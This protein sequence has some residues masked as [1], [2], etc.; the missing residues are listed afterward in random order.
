M[1]WAVSTAFAGIALLVS[2]CAGNSR[3]AVDRP[4]P[5][6]SSAGADA[7]L[8]LRTTTSG[9]FAGFGGPGSIPDF[10]LYGDGRAIVR[11]PALT[12]YRLTPRALKRLVTAAL[13]AGLATP[14]TVDDP[15]VA[16][17]M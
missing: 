13:D 14:R 3:A 9:G 11:S 5:A 1:K 16:D 7:G 12:E 15:K 17:A 8:V 4:A 2:G 10:S 6:S